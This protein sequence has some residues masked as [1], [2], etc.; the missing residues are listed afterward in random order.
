MLGT[1][2][3]SEIG[4][5]T[6]TGGLNSLNSNLD[7]KINKYDMSGVKTTFGTGGIPYTCEEDCFI[8]VSRF[9]SSSGEVWIQVNGNNYAC[10]NS[11]TIY[12]SV[13]MNLNKGDVITVNGN[14]N[15]NTRFKVY[16]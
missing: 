13:T 9:A 16:K 5:G 1:T 6:V 2:D 15:T 7:K 8:V 4:D 14:L 11:S 12:T 10:S 3:I